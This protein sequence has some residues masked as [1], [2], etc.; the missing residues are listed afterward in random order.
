MKL[1]INKILSQTIHTEEKDNS[2]IIETAAIEIV[3]IEIIIITTMT[4]IIEIIKTKES[5]ITTTEIIKVTIQDTI[6][7]QIINLRGKTSN[8]S[9]V[10]MVLNKDLIN[11]EI[12]IKIIKAST[13]NK[14]N[15]III[16]I[17][18]IIKIIMRGA[19][20]ISNKENITIT[21]TILII[22]I[23]ILLA[24]ATLRA[25]KA[26]NTTLLI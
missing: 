26:Q 14:E 2:I 7:I 23:A 25:N 12:L 16:I 18:E 20:N 3:N 8:N 24:I 4:I 1:K 22:A 15:P 21:T 6:K 19:I 10:K 17:K 11:K 9:K 5:L 13:I